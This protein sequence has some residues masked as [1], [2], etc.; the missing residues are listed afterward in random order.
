[1][2]EHIY[3]KVINGKTYY[4][5]QKTYREKIKSKDSGKT[6]GSGKSRVRTRSVYLGTARSIMERLSK[7][8]DP[9]EVRHRDFGLVA[10]A[11]QTAKEIGLVDLLREHIPGERYGV[12]RWLYFLLPILVHPPLRLRN[13]PDLRPFQY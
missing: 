10:A 4:Y 12:S 7:S 11:L 2:A 8:Q 6:R 13:G 3:P 5:L 9:V 1:M